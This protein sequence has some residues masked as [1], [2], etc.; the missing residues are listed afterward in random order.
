M[1]ME[2]REQKKALLAKER[3]AEI[4][5]IERTGIGDV[6]IFDQFGNLL[7][8]RSTLTITQHLRLLGRIPSDDTLV[9]GDVSEEVKSKMGTIPKRPTPK[10]T[11]STKRRNTKQSG[12]TVTS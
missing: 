12:A 7:P 9:T 11:H 6:R 3:R 1:A 8:P 5:E 2:E 10:G 4:A